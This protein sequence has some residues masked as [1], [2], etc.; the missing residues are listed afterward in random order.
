MGGRLTGRSVGKPAWRFNLL[1]KGSGV[2]FRAPRPPRAA[3]P[4]RALLA[5]LLF[6]AVAAAAAF[7]FHTTPFGRVAVL[8][9]EGKNDD[10]NDGESPPS[11]EQT[12]VGAEGAVKRPVVKFGVFANRDD[13]ESL[14]GSLQKQDIFA[15][16]RSAQ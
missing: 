10:E 8:I 16:I 7:Y 5:V 11:A 6:V 15:E 12:A 9:G 2:R 3:W 4:K 14:A 1:Y 13:A